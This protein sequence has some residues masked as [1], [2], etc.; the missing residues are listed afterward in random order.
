M[1]HR[2]DHSSANAH[3]VMFRLYCYLKLPF[4]FAPPQPPSDASPGQCALVL[5]SKETLVSKLQLP[6][7]AS[8]SKYRRYSVVVSSEM[9]IL[10]S[11]SFAPVLGLNLHSREV[12]AVVGAHL[13]LEEAV[14]CCARVEVAAEVSWP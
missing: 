12:E 7:L 3:S 10:S 11:A 13:C 14:E 2:N 9:P 8:L 5:L 6:S 1:R 4:F